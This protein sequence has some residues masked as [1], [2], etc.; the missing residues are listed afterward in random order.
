M[1]FSEVVPDET[2]ATCPLSEGVLLLRSGTDSELVAALPDHSLVLWFW[3]Y[4][5]I[6]S[7]ATLPVVEAKYERVPSDGLLS[8]AGAGDRASS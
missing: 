6:V 2:T 5:W 7:E 4:V 1:A 8:N 3:R